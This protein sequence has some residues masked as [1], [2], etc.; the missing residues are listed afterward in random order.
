MV[1]TQTL[2]AAWYIRHVNIFSRLRPFRIEVLR[3]RKKNALGEKTACNREKKKATGTYAKNVARQKKAIS[4]QML[5]PRN[6]APANSCPD[7]TL[8]VVER[9]SRQLIKTASE[10]CDLYGRTRYLVPIVPL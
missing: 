3:K 9:S 7:L 6:S 10:G 4:T 1:E 8:L 2:Q 5:R